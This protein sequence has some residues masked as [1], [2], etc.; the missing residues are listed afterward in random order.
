MGKCHN[1]PPKKGKPKNLNKPI[2]SLAGQKAHV[3]ETSGAC[4]I[5]L[6]IVIPR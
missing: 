1:A 5:K 6:S 4:A 2:N 3:G